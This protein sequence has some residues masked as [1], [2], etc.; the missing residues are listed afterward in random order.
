MKLLCCLALF[1][2]VGVVSQGQPPKF[3][4][5]KALLPDEKTLAII[6]EKA[7]K[8][9][10]AIKSLPAKTPDYIRNDIEIHLKAIDW[11]LRYNEFFDGGKAALTTLEQGLQRA[12]DAATGKYPWLQAAGK[13]VVRAYRSD[14]DGSLQPFAVTYPHG[15]GDGKTKNWRLDVVLHG[16]D[17]TICETKFL[18]QNNNKEAPKANGFIQIDIY[19]RGNNAYRW[20]GERDVFEAIADFR[21]VEAK[22]TRGPIETGRIVLRG[23]SMGGAGTWHLGLHHPGFFSVIGPGAGFTT[24][25][26]YVK[27]LPNPLPPYQEPLLHIYDAVDYAEN[28]F[29][30]PIVAY[31]GEKDPQKAAADNIEARLNE[32]K[33]KGMTHLIAPGL[34]HKFPPEWQAKAEVE[35]KKHVADDTIQGPP[36]EIRLVTYTTKY[37]DY[38]WLRIVLL[39]KHYQKAEVRAVRDD[40]KVTV[41]TKNVRMLSIDPPKLD[42]LTIDG[43]KVPASDLTRTYEKV[44]GEWLVGGGSTLKSLQKRANLQGPIDDAFMA[45]FLCVRGTG[46]AWSPAMAKAADAQLDRFTREWDKWMRGTLV[47]KNDKDVTE[48]D[49][50]AKHLILFGDPGSNTLIAKSLKGLP[51]TWTK[52]QLVVDNTKYESGKHL[53]LLVYPNPL[54]P[55]RYLV[56]NSGHTFHEADFKG[57]NALLFP[58]LGDWAVV[59]PAPTSTDPAAFELLQSGIFDDQWRFEKLGAK[60]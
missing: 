8:L 48:D 52:E 5:P 1:M 4:P 45:P 20:A 54:N 37:A 16:R 34:E 59:K 41:T 44:G 38:E 31:S 46:T 47:V 49:I 18:A 40:G 30:L 14:V 43:Q 42:T 9:S 11:A 3:D 36:F 13:K 29:N 21:A 35:F 33:I 15:Y 6:K 60:Q 22:Q 51:I 32:L 26:A 55:N 57:T 23:F 2:L 39:D 24:T 12:A 50:K 7:A 25:H 10:E 17:G 28:A 19:G 27:T 53:P 58:K 56:F